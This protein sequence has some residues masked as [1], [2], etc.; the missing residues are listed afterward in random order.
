M[1]PLPFV[2]TLPPSQLPAAPSIALLLCHSHRLLRL[3]FQSTAAHTRTHFA[4]QFITTVSGA[5]EHALKVAPACTLG[6]NTHIQ[7]KPTVQCWGLLIW[8]IVTSPYEGVLKNVFFFK[9]SPPCRQA[10]QEAAPHIHPVTI[11]A[12]LRLHTRAHSHRVSLQTLLHGPWLTTKTNSVWFKKFVRN[13]P[14]MPEAMSYGFTGNF[15]VLVT[16]AVIITC[17][18]FSLSLLCRR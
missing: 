16:H 12:D 2:P 5:A 8:K 7:Y 4:T 13:Y 15:Q 14:E 10:R 6:L 18:H 11:H 1:F 9:H 17:F 3:Q